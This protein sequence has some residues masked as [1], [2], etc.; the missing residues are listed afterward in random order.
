MGEKR[1]L[2]LKACVRD[3]TPLAAWCTREAEP[4]DQVHQVDTYFPVGQGRLK[5]RVVEGAQMGTLIFYDRTDQAGP[6]RSRVNLLQV[7]DPNQV[8]TLLAEA[9]GV[10]VEVRKRRRIFRWGQV[11]IHLDEVEE[12]GAFL[13]FER[14]IE[15]PEEEKRAQAEFATLRRALDLRD[16]DLVVGSYSDL[17]LGG[18]LDPRG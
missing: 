9:L 4:V 14:P 12:L 11:Q 10:L 13:E 3:L 2:E 18:E 6:K 7:A 1:L 17:L 16:Q 8:R 15:A 5:V